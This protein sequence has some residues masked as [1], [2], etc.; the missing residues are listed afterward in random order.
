MPRDPYFFPFEIVNKN[1]LIPGNNY[2]M[3]LCS[4]NICYTQSGLFYIV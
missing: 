3:K 1:E 2:Y 4:Y